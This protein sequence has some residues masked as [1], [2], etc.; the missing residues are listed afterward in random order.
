MDA[1]SLMLYIRSRSLSSG[2]AAKPTRLERFAREV[3]LR[4]T[5]DKRD[6]SGD[7]QSPEDIAPLGEQ[8][9]GNRFDEPELRIY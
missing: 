2:N 3:R 9:S 7:T 4:G 1:R 5:D 8:L 6:R